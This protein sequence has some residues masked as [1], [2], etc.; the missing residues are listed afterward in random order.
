[1]AVSITT[2]KVQAGLEAYTYV[3]MTSRCA[4]RALCIYECMEVW[5]EVERGIE[6]GVV[7]G[8]VESDEEGGEEGTGT[9]MFSS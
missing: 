8:G 9:S 3:T 2:F 1:M 5:M 6:R 4:M 7:E